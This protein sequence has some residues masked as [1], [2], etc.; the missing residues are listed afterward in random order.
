M[1]LAENRKTARIE[2]RTKRSIYKR[3]YRTSRQRKQEKRGGEKEKQ[4]HR[5][6]SKIGCRC[7]KSK[8]STKMECMKYMTENLF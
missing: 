8:K 2:T 4:Y 7:H 5:I 1:E 3:T 6:L